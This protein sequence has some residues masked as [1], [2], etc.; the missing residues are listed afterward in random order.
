MVILTPE[1]KLSELGGGACHPDGNIRITPAARWACR[2][3]RHWNQRRHFVG[4]GKL[5]PAAIPS[6]PPDRRDQKAALEA[7]DEYATLTLAE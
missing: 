3:V 1:A 4:G 5:S 2:R 7:D 6:T